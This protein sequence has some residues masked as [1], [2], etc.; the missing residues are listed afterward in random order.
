MNFVLHSLIVHTLKKYIQ[1]F[2]TFQLSLFQGEIVLSKISTIQK[3]I[4][5]FLTY[6]S[7]NIRIYKGNI[8]KF[9][10]LIPW[11]SLTSKSIQ[12]IASEVIIN[13]H[14]SYFEQ[15]LQAEKSLFGIKEEIKYGVYPEVDESLIK[16]FLNRV[17]NNLKVSLEKIL[18]NIDLLDIYVLQISLNELEIYNCKED[19][20]EYDYIQSKKTV[21]KL[22]ILKEFR[23]KIISKTGKELELLKFDLLQIKIFIKK[24]QYVFEIKNLNDSV[25]SLDLGLLRFFLEK[26]PE[27]FF[28]EKL[29][30]KQ[31]PIAFLLHNNIE[32][33][34]NSFQ[35]KYFLEKASFNIVN[36]FEDEITVINQNINL[37]NLQI[38][39][40]SGASLQNYTLNFKKLELFSKGSLYLRLNS[41]DICDYMWK[42][43]KLYNEKNF[44]NIIF[45]VNEKKQENSQTYQY[46]FSLIISKINCFLQLSLFLKTFK[47]ILNIYQT[48]MC[49]INLFLAKIQ[50]KIEIQ[51]INSNFLEKDEKNQNLTITPKIIYEYSIKFLHNRIEIFTKLTELWH[52]FLYFSTTI[53]YKGILSRK[54]GLIKKFNLNIKPL[55][56]RLEN[57]KEIK[58]LELVNSEF[59]YEKF[60]KKAR[61]SNI[62]LV[63]CELLI[64]IVKTTISDLNMLIKEI[65]N[66]NLFEF[67]KEKNNDK[68]S[69]LNK[70]YQF[71][72]Q[73]KIMNFNF[74]L[75]WLI[76]AN[77]QKKEIFKE[78]FDLKLSKVELFSIDN[79]SFKENN[80]NIPI[81][82]YKSLRFNSKI[83]VFY[84]D[85]LFFESMNV[86][87]K[88]NIN[89]FYDFLDPQ[90]NKLEFLNPILL[91]LNP[92]IINTIL[93][94][95]NENTSATLI[96]S[97]KNETNHIIYLKYHHFIKNEEVL[98]LSPGQTTTLLLSNK[99][100]DSHWNFYQIGR[101]FHPDD[102]DPFYSDKFHV[103]YDKNK[104]IKDFYKKV[105]VA[106]ILPQ[107]ENVFHLKTINLEKSEVLCIFADWY[108]IN[109]LMSQKLTLL[110]KTNELINN[111]N[112]NEIKGKALENCKDNQKHIENLLKSN[113]KYLDL[114]FLIQEKLFLN[115][116][117]Y[118]S[119]IE[120]FLDTSNEYLFSNIN[121]QEIEDKSFHIYFKK[122]S[123]FKFLTHKLYS[124]IENDQNPG[125][126]LFYV[127]I[128]QIAG[129]NF[130]IIKPFILISNKTDKL[131]HLS[132]REY[133]NKK[134]QNEQMDLYNIN[135]E[136]FYSLCSSPSTNIFCTQIF[137]DFQIIHHQFNF[138]GQKIVYKTFK[139][140]KTASNSHILQFS[141]ENSFN[142][143]VMLANRKIEESFLLEFD[144]P[145]EISNESEYVIIIKIKKF[146]DTIIIQPNEKCQVL[147]HLKD[148]SETLFFSILQKGD[149]LLSNTK[150]IEVACNDLFMEKI[151]LLSFN[152]TKLNEDYLNVTNLYNFKIFLYN[153]RFF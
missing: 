19:G 33:L 125:K 32:M 150:A 93:F 79:A 24:E 121:H 144:Y 69:I 120:D 13:L 97:F 49:E 73:V 25:I 118:H 61:I 119:T 4:N 62:K 116:Y 53:D 132:L 26:I 140:E 131:I 9:K 34:K 105:I 126:N 67:L 135:P 17:I 72:I 94:L 103:S 117:D 70:D 115:Q 48:I 37:L 14:F 23:V 27:F 101:K 112:F 31:I 55:Q 5:Q 142:F 78:I 41:I 75:G 10:L 22:F 21:S 65:K 8:S 104:S 84:I 100:I 152:F 16:K 30:S 134:D 1:N 74:W 50:E 46:D 40:L 137:F 110:S 114:E 138:Q 95:V 20:I 51:R 63:I 148:S 52:Y 141:N 38:E 7:E 83:E 6:Y 91:N 96:K 102:E 149:L 98:V 58:I 81:Q 136:S 127:D 29:K 145:L 66:E 44:S 57:L 64:R 39:Y 123:N 146:I 89:F 128:F 151:N 12:L 87:N 15:L 60:E 129:V 56:L 68:I 71:N 143:E 43:P 36:N 108:L 11:S 92:E 109:L 45:Q 77:P 90:K 42:F 76:F 59:I 99:K 82:N 85:D 28:K 139:E 130:S 2:E 124:K 54:T 86:L 147:K 111:Q 113:N 133:L 35:L 80:Q 88:V 18:I 106:G 153:F 47:E 107:E 122:N 3:S